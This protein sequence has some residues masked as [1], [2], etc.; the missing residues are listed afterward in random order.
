MDPIG[1]SNTWRWHGYEN[2]WVLV[3]GTEMQSVSGGGH[4]GG[5]LFVST[6]D[7]ARFGLLFLRRGVWNG[8]RLFSG[9]WI[10]MLRAPAEAFPGYGYMWW[11]NTGKRA[12]KDAPENIYYA[13]GFGGN[14]IVVDEQNDLVV[15]VRWM[16]RLNDFLKIVLDAVKDGELLPSPSRKGQKPGKEAAFGADPAIIGPWLGRSEIPG[17]GID[18]FMLVFAKAEGGLTGN[19]TDTLGIIEK[20]T[21]LSEIKFG[22]DKTVTFQFPLVD[23]TIIF[24]KLA[25][26]QDKMTGTWQS[27]D[28]NT[29]KLEFARKK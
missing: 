6:R 4:F 20:D 18:D 28:G 21:R 23:S 11:L 22:A 7:Q 17:Q 10:D 27:P 5:G 16:P 12:L 19:I 13:S 29:G 14:F 15:V 8:N 1:A 2:S 24:F 9:K 26:E 3:D 25:F